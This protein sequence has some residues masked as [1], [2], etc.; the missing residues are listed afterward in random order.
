MV[1]HLGDIIVLYDLEIRA[2]KIPLTCK[3]ISDCGGFL[4][5]DHEPAF[6]FLSLSF[7]FQ[8]DYHTLV[9]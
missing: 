8:S 2:K 4:D 1:L 5:M 6:I 7:C 3:G 9:V